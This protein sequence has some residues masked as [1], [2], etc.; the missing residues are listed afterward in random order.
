MIDEVRL[1]P[2]TARMITYA[3]DGQGNVTSV[4]DE[5][6]RIAYT[7]YDEFNRV[8]LVRDTDR[9]IVEHHSYNF[10]VN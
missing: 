9:N 10:R 3:Y 1:H 8:K 5:N 7:E 4:C 2:T 6:N